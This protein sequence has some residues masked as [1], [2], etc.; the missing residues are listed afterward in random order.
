MPSV[1]DERFFL[2]G[3]YGQG[4]LGDDLLLRATV[5]GFRRIRP[6]A[7]FVIRNEGPVR[8]LEDFGGAIELTGIDR[9]LA[10]QSK[11]K[12][13]RLVETLLAYRRHFSSCH[14]FVFGGG[15]VFHERSSAAPL[16][17]TLM[18]CVLARAMGLQ[19][20]ALGVGISGLRSAPA[21]IALRAIIS[22][23]ALF[24]VR[25]DAALAECVKAGAWKRVKLTGDLAFTLAPLLTGRGERAEARANRCVG[26][27]VYPPALLNEGGRAA[28]SA[29]QSA[30]KALL[31][32]GWKIS[33]LAFHDDP[34]KANGRQDK[35]ILARLM[36]GLSQDQQ[37]RVSL[38]V[39]RA[40]SGEISQIF[41]DVDVYCGM[42]FHG[43]VL[44]A[45]FGI[46]FVGIS[47]DN[48]IDA[49]CRLFG[50]P[51]FGVDRIVAER[52]V[53]AVEHTRSRKLE[54]SLREACIA[55][56][57]QNFIEFARLLSPN[58]ANA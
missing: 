4:N 57:E 42:R 30:L 47:T 41:S 40:N 10:N 53:D 38:Q 36:E 31:E 5:D 37:S 9:I 39:V 11:S 13:G 51:V 8:S 43:H 26:F 6:Q 50:M 33:L 24:A 56:A 15:T 34:E 2:F 1:S 27:S 14:W 23:S 22:M 21:R 45:I 32:R 49:I 19:I 12:V 29:I 7:T 46:P 17:L 55:G 16:L 28:F 44:A 3:F 52:L 18:I 20:A 35:D 54:M 48:K 25:D 58:P